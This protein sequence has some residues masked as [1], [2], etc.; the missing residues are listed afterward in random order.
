MQS[1]SMQIS[2]NLKRFEFLTNSV[3]LEFFIRIL[4]QFNWKVVTGLHSKKYFNINEFSNIRL[5][6]IH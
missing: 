5:Y 4:I 6:I 1:R 3:L 2:I